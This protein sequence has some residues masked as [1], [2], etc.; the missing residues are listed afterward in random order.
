MRAAIAA[1]MALGLN[2]L[3]RWVVA[4]LPR[5][6]AVRFEDR[7][8]ALNQAGGRTGSHVAQ[9]ELEAIYRDGLARLDGTPGDCLEFGVYTGTT[10]ACLYRAVEG[11]GLDGVR[12]F[13]FDSFEGMP[14]TAGDEAGDHSRAGMFRAG[15][16]E[17]AASLA[18]AGVDMDRVT[19]VKGWFD[20]TLTEENRARLGIE[21]VRLAMLDC[22]VYSSAKA[23]LDFCAPLLADRAVLVFDDWVHGGAGAG[24]QRAFRELL[25]EHPELR[26]EEIG[27]YP[28]AG[29]PDGGRAF[30]VRRTMPAH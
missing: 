18:R 20:D 8:Y 6:F 15:L 2:R 17:T 28:A 14:A 9:A 19:L 16:D 1:A 27:A 26:A 25:T 22:D 4:R 24:E 11:L 29:H 5:R 3:A 30:L 23:A 13:G 7:V 10:L 12:I 21:R